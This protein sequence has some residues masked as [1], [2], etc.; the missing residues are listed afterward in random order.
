MTDHVPPLEA[1]CGSWVV[2]RRATGEV[3]GEFYDRRNVARFNPATCLIETAQQYL[4]RVNRAIKEASVPE[5][6]TP[7][8][9]MLR[10]IADWYRL[11]AHAEEWASYY[12]P[13]GGMPDA[14]TAA[15]WTRKAKVYRDTARALRLELETG[16]PHC[17]CHLKTE[18]ERQYWDVRC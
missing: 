15:N 2:T 5:T 14:G 3:I 4:G 16:E 12:A 11:A 18:A 8:A 7:L 6:T 17:A 1:H 13:T 9:E 10:A